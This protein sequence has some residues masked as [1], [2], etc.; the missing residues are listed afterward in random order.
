MPKQDVL[1]LKFFYNNEDYNFT[2][3]PLL[4]KKYKFLNYLNKLIY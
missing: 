2:P 1:T 4:S 3:N